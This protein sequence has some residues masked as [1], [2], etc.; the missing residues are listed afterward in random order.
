[1]DGSDILSWLWNQAVSEWTGKS[2]QNTRLP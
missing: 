1:V 2:L